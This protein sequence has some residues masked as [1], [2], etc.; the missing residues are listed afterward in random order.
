MKTLWRPLPLDTPV[1]TVSAML[2]VSGTDALVATCAP[3]P[4]PGVNWIFDLLKVIQWRNSGPLPRKVVREV[5]RHATVE[6]IGVAQELRP[7]RAFKLAEVRWPPFGR[8]LIQAVPAMRLVT[9][10]QAL[11]SLPALQD[12]RYRAEAQ[13]AEVR[14]LYGRMLG[15]IAYRIENSALFD[16]AVPLT[17]QFGAAM[18]LWAAIDDATPDAEVTRRASLAKVTFDAARAHA[19]TVG[20]AHLP[21]TARAPARRAAGAAR[22]A[23]NTTVEAEREAAMAGAIQLLESLALYYLP[24]PDDFRAAIE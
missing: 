4:R 14:E 10:D 18:A 9:V 3:N 2:L 6:S 20:I 8:P 23:A 13:M 12:A 15:D 22:L 1:E 21:E 16:S 17:K 24:G 11:K 5:S 19:E 7:E